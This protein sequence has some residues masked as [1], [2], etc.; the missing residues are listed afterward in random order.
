MSPIY[1]HVKMHVLPMI[2]VMQLPISAQRK[3]GTRQVHQTL[4]DVS[5]VH[6]TQCW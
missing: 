3:I 5:N 2:I 4:E 6:K 1:K